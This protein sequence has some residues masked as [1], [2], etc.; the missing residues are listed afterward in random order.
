[1]AP[2]IQPQIVC[3]GIAISILAGPGVQTLFMLTQNQTLEKR[4]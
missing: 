1:M 3:I 4:K 2:V